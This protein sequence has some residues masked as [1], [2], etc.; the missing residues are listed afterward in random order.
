MKKYWE[1]MPHG[2]Y[3]D[4]PGTNEI[5]YWLRSGRIPEGK[6]YVPSV[7]IIKKD[8]N[9]QE[10][11]KFLKLAEE[12]LMQLSRMDRPKWDRPVTTFA[13]IL[14]AIVM[15]E[16]IYEY[17]FGVFFMLYAQFQHQYNIE[18]HK[19]QINTRKKMLKIIELE[20]EDSK[21]NKK[22]M[23][24]KYKRN[25]KE[26]TEPLPVYIRNAIVHQGTN[27]SNQF[28]PEELEIAI[29]FLRQTLRNPRIV[30]Q[31]KEA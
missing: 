6:N 13:H 8:G 17:E 21:F 28:A 1:P 31:F 9:E 2:S 14:R 16:G 11:I 18:D 22:W 26:L 25:G 24:K 27:A 7:A 20:D 5:M 19:E 4:M 10:K 29:Y 12:A 30:K 3:I 15:D 23:L